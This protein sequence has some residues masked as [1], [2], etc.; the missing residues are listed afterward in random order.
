MLLALAQWLQN[1]SFAMFV[2]GSDWAYPF[3][4]ATHFTGLSFWVATNVALDLRLLGFGKNRETAAQLSQN[5]FI[6]NWIGFA[7]AITGGF[8]LF[9]S[10]ATT[11]VPNP[12]FDAK[13]AFFLPVALIIHI[14]VQR[15]SRVWGA[16]SEVQSAGKIAGG[17]ELLLWLC[18]VTAA[19]SI[20]YF[21]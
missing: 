9:S 11:Y 8:L 10:A 15:K 16:N 17:I 3:V 5:L 19:V 21:G 13:L 14:W 1:T 4:Q 7:V 20:P 12:A 2:S 6:W 18:V